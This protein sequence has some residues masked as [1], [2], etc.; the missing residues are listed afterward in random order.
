MLVGLTGNLLLGYWEELSTVGNHTTV[1]TENPLFW[2]LG[3]LP[4]GRCCPRELVEKLSFLVPQKPET[5][6]SQGRCSRVL[7]WGDTLEQAGQ[8]SLWDGI[9][10][11]WL[12][13]VA[14]A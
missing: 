12:P 3:K 4:M 11:C 7:H 1:I 10:G 6:N 8:N 14:R 5:R 13:C 9:A 2:G